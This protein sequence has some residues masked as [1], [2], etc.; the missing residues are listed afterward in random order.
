MNKSPR[1]LPA[2]WRNDAT[3]DRV[4]DWKN[5]LVSTFLYGSISPTNAIQRNVIIDIAFDV[6]I[7]FLGF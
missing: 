1:R 2:P 6:E 4:H 7:Q 5:E 3:T